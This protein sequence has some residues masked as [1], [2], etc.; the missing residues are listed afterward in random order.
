LPGA[1]KF[2]RVA[3]G[4]ADAYPRST[5]C[6]AWDIAAGQA[7]VEAAGGVVLA[8]DGSALRYRMLP[9]WPVRGFL[10]LGDAQVFTAALQG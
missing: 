10:A 5:A 2:C 9:G 8:E 1:L 6:S 4:I 7:L 3:E